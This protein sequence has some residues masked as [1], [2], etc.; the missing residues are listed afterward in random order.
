MQALQRAWIFHGRLSALDEKRMLR[1][2]TAERDMKPKKKQRSL[3]DVAWEYRRRRYSG[4]IADQI[5][6]EEAFI[7]GARWG[8]RRAVGKI[9]GQK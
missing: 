1:M 5:E 4:D 8:K 2:L 7:A 3:R 6:I 9:E